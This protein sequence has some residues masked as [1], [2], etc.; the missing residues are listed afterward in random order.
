MK[1]LLLLYGDADKTGI[2]TALWEAYKKGAQESGAAIR[3]LHIM[4]LK[5]NP[6][7]QFSNRV[8]EL[9]IDLQLALEQL[10]KANHIVLFCTVNSDSIAARLS[11]FF[12]RLFLPNQVFPVGSASFNN[13]FSGKSAR[14]VSVL[15]EASWEEWVET[16]VPT[17]HSIKRSVLEQCRIKPVHTCTI[18]YLHTL[19]NGYAQKWLRKMEGFGKK[20]L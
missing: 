11:G 13:N 12:D 7:K 3:E 20:I 18:G 1:N 10:H 5:F 4:D 15:D 6:N 2:N 17:Y 8:A 14:I 9:E 16:K 19:K